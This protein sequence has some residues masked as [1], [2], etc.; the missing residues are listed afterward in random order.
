MNYPK[1][2]L[3]IKDVVFN[4]YK[5]AKI[6]LTRFIE[7]NYPVLMIG[8]AEAGEVYAIC[9]INPWYEKLNDYEFVIKDYSEN[10]GIFNWL[11]ENDFIQKPHRFIQSGYTIN[12]VCYAS[13]SLKQ[14]IN[15]FQIVD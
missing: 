7:D 13:D 12:S 14:F 9:N 5:N 15:D 2:P 6:Y 3:F 1:Y 11:I 4:D 10:E 8:N